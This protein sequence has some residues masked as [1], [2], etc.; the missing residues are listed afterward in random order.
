[1]S[2]VKTF[3]VRRVAGALGAEVDGAVPQAGDG[4]PFLRLEPGERAGQRPFSRFADEPGRV[5][6]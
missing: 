6:V 2:L 3:D 4:H 5:P 1:M